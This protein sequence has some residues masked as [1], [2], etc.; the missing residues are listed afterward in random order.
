MADLIHSLHLLPRSIIVRVGLRPQELNSD[1]HLTRLTHPFIGQG[2]QM[3][4]GA[5]GYDL[6]FQCASDATSWFPPYILIK[7]T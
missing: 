1:T 4:G 5:K 6:Q 2:D 3:R 7:Q